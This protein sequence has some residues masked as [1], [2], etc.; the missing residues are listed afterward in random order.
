MDP[1]EKN[2]LNDID[3]SIEIIKKNKDGKIIEKEEVE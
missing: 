2:F 3:I 1:N